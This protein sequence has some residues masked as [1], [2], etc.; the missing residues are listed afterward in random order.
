MIRVV[1]PD[2]DPDFLPITDPGVKRH[3]IPDPDPQHVKNNTHCVA[4]YCHAV[5]PP[6]AK[7][8][9]STF[10]IFDRNTIPLTMQDTTISDKTK[11]ILLLLILPNCALTSYDTES[12]S[13]GS[14]S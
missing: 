4:I 12:T 3:R 13:C 10:H 8:A 2:P 7:P 6:P 1:H 11:N 14:G 9:I 5:Y